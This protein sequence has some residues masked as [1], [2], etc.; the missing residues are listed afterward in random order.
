MVKDS[1]E[2]WSSDLSSAG[3][4]GDELENAMDVCALMD[5]SFVGA[6]FTWSN[7]HVFCKL[8]RC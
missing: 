6:V 4:V 3:S 2:K 8:D 1:S 7:N 5:H